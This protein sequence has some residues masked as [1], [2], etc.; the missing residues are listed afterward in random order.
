MIDFWRCLDASRAR[1]LAASA[2]D[3]VVVAQLDRI[4]GTVSRQT[5]QETALIGSPAI[6]S[7]S[8]E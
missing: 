2:D 5:P 4:A 3:A 6:R 1:S 7:L 8:F